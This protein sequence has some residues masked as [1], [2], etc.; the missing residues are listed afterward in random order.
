MSPSLPFHSAAQSL[1][2]QSWFGP[3]HFLVEFSLVLG[4]SRRR[5]WLFTT[6]T[7]GIRLEVSAGKSIYDIDSPP[8]F[9]Y[10][11]VGYL[12]INDLPVET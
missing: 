8:S 10:Q 7:L 4:Q 12:E 11:S 2:P 9:V 5:F 1:F 3:T 6:I